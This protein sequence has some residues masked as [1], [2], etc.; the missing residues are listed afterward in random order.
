[1]VELKVFLEERGRVEVEAQELPETARKNRE[2]IIELGNERAM[3]Y[4]RRSGN[5]SLEFMEE[6]EGIVSGM[7]A[8]L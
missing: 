7:G 5:D 1:M 6:I 2:R 8:I 3:F 4:F